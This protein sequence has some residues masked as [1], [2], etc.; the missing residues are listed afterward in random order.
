MT[1]QPN[2]DR[3]VDG[4]Q[5]HGR[6]GDPLS[7]VGRPPAALSFWGRWWPAMAV[8]AVTA[9]AV[10]V[11]W[12]GLRAHDNQMWGDEATLMTGAR[13]FLSGGQS[14]PFTIDALGNPAFI[15]FL[16]AQAFR[17]TGVT[18]EAARA[19]FGLW[20]AL[21]IPLLYGLARETG[22]RRSTALAAAALLATGSWHAHLSRLV[23]INITGATTVEAVLFCV[24]ATLRRR[25][26]L[27]ASLTGVS[28]FVAMNSY[29]GARVLFP[30]LGAWL[31]CLILFNGPL[32]I[33]RPAATQENG[34]PTA[35]TERLE[36]TS[37]F[38]R[39]SA[40]R[41]LAS[42]GIALITALALLL[43]L[44]RYYLLNPGSFS[45]HTED[46]F[47]FG[48][49][50]MQRLL[51]LHPELPHNVWGVIQYQF[52]ATIGMFAT[53]GSTDMWSNMPGRPILD[54]LSS[55]FFLIGLLACLWTW[56]R[57][58]S[59]LLLSWILTVSFF[60]VFLTVDPP[61][62]HKPI[63]AA[64][65]LALMIT[66]GIETTLSLL[67]G[68]W[69]VAAVRFRLNRNRG[70]AGSIRRARDDDEPARGR[71]G[72]TWHGDIVSRGLL[73]AA[74]TMIG[75]VNIQRLV[76]YETSPGYQAFM[77][78]TALAWARYLASIRAPAAAVDSPLGY[79]GEFPSL[80]APRATLCN[81]QWVGQWQRCPATRVIIFDRGGDSDAQ[82]Y[83]AITHRRAYPGAAPFGQPLYW[84][85]A[86]AGPTP[87]PD[88]AIVLGH[89]HTGA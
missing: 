73:F 24:V 89:I 81:A 83:A 17:L 80:F 55:I 7:T 49:S 10:A 1:V 18:V 39:V 34:R 46:V 19:Y 11:R 62:A 52:W 66:L 68:F 3:A 58:L 69:N 31:L 40:R 45:G 4:T 20:G 27:W 35:F 33:Q 67:A 2:I 71:V 42:G 14:D 77:T 51:G 21:G 22:V 44:L 43:P 47:A 56:R 87:L 65:A 70:P 85:V 28:L 74:V 13:Q 26:L 37:P 63:P 38:F 29:I 76:V 41:L 64:P 86:S 48:P 53:R 32:Q 30:L 25:S 61:T 57:P 8:L 9:L 23:V 60:G 5:Q 78:N 6:A 15:S 50:A 88:P 54:G 82:R 72:S 79:A 16:L 84:Y 59:T 12:W 75:V 36:L